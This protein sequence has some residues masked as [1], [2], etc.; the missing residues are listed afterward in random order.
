MFRKDVV[1]RRD[2]LEEL[3]AVIPEPGDRGV[4]A[5]RYVQGFSLCGWYATERLGQIYFET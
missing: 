5:T 2:S 4:S 1:Y 3:P